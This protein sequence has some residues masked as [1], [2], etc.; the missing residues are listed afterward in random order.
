MKISKSLRGMAL[1]TALGGA[2][3]TMGSSVAFA[4][5]T[6]DERSACMGDAFRFCSSAIPDVPQIEACLKA[7]LSQLS[8][9]CRAEFEPTGRSRLRREYFR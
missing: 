9:E 1:L 2:I 7:N 3:L 5:G 6:P 4:Q 8:P